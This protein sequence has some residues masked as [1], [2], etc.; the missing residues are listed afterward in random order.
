[1]VPHA[2]APDTATGILTGL[3]GM[4]VEGVVVHGRYP[5]E[6]TAGRQEINRLV[7][8]LLANSE[9][10]TRTIRA[11][12]PLLEKEIRS[13]RHGNFL[14]GHKNHPYDFPRIEEAIGT[15]EYECKTV[16]ELISLDQPAPL[17]LR[18]SAERLK[19]IKEFLS[20]VEQIVKPVAKSAV[21]V[22]SELNKVI[23]AVTVLVS[24]IMALLHLLG[25]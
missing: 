21:N 24:L 15:L 22:V 13:G 10:Q 20:L 12:Q 8:D 17:S 3:S 2:W 23:I 1:M 5:D 4:A 11:L 6:A 9:H 19:Q 18:S 16:R 14:G 7:D 25:H